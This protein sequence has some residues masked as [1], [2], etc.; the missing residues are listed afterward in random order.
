M[1]EV[2][3]GAVLEELSRQDQASDTGKMLWC[4]VEGMPYVPQ[5]A[6]KYGAKNSYKQRTKLEDFH[7][8]NILESFFRHRTQHTGR[9]LVQQLHADACDVWRC[10]KLYT[11]SIIENKLKASH[12]RR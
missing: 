8:W 2:L 6:F 3:A 4:E 9:L 5:Q 11:S 10:T 7:P 1:K 12:Q